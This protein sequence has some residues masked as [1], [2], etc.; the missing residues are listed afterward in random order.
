VDGS[1]TRL[2]R[3]QH[4]RRPAV[5]ARQAVAELPAVVDPPAG[6]SIVLPCFDEEGNVAEAIRAASAAAAACAQDYEVMVVDD[7]SRDA[8]GEI[9][10][11][12]AAVDPRVRVVVHERNRGYGEALRSGLEAARMPWC[13]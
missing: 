8:T 1:A 5:V 9:A 11:A 3:K 7:G 12:C 10:R 13:C 6:V 4:D 2:G